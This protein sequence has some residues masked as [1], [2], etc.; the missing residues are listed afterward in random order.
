MSRSVS[1]IS[2]Y[3]EHTSWIET[4]DLWFDCAIRKCFVIILSC[5]YSSLFVVVVVVI[6]FCIAHSLAR[7]RQVVAMV[8]TEQQTI[9]FPLAF[10]SMD[11]LFAAN[12]T[13]K[14]RF[15]I[16][17]SVPSAFVACIVPFLCYCIV[18]WCVYYY[19]F[20]TCA[21]ILY[22]PFLAF[23][24]LSIPVFFPANVFIFLRIFIPLKYIFNAPL[25]NRIGIHFFIR[26]NNIQ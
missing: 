20:S 21:C 17:F 22:I 11:F 10:I 26:T 16:W 6:P 24:A 15:C 12:E 9:I 14:C 4:Y 5:C 18:H 23:N 25:L 19:K 3:W 8:S 2:F 1:C 13:E 7:C